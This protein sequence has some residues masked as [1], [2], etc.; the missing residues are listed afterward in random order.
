MTAFD[1]LEWIR[2]FF[3]GEDVCEALWKKWQVLKAE[4]MDAPGWIRVEIDRNTDEVMQALEYLPVGAHRVRSACTG[5]K[6][7]QTYPD[8]KS[9]TW[10]SISI[11]L[12]RGN[13]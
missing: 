1:L 8:L 3:P 12:D 13:N 10:W 11:P 6:L 4:Y 5:G 9:E 7:F 2:E